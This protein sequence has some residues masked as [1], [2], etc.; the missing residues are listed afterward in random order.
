MKSMR[1]APKPYTLNP[2][3]IPLSIVAPIFALLT[4]FVPIPREIV[5]SFYSQDMYPWL[6]NIFTG[7]TNFLPFAVLDAI[8]ILLVLAV[9][10]R[11]RRLFYVARQRGIFDAIWELARRVARALAIF[12]ILFF[13]AWGFNYRRQPLEGQLPKGQVNRPTLEALQLAVIDGNALAGRLRASVMAGPAL[14]FDQVADRLLAPLNTALKQLGRPPLSREGHPKYSLVLT[15]FFTSAGITGM[16]NPLALETIVH[17]DLLPFERPFVLA[18][19]WAHLSGHADEAE[20]SA[21]GWLACMKGG[22]ELAYSG[23]LYLIDAA[24]GAL[25]AD[26]RKEVLK[27]LDAGV[28]TD[29]EAILQRRSAARDNVSQTTMRVYDEYLRANSVADGG[30]SYRRALSLIL[31]PK[32]RDSLANYTITR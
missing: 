11:L 2:E 1:P 10:F 16:L 6:Q 25:P 19:E 27:K 31:A 23:S 3:P 4:V 8:V 17:P 29:L 24:S 18:H 5:E 12:T 13:W 7:A 9:L 32:L 26:L 14:S 30:A 21:I 20:A 15:P 28:T 22:Y